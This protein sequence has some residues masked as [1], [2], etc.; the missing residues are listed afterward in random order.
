M[1]A[2]HFVH[3]PYK[4]SDRTSLSVNL[5]VLP[6]SIRLT[7][8]IVKKGRYKTRLYSNIDLRLTI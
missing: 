3:A 8:E 2:L 5:G 6:S 4:I 1:G 7:I